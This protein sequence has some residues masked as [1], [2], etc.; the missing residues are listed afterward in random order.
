MDTIDIYRA[1]KLLIERY[2]EDATLEAAARAD[3]LR[4]EGDLDG[5]KVWRGIMK[6]TREFQRDKPK[7][8]E[9]VM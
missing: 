6:A 5:A 2:G 9:R 3:T 8:G 4:D 7:K 1:A